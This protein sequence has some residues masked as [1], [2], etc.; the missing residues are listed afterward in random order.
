MAQR[1][2]PEVDPDNEEIVVFFR[3]L[4]VGVGVGVCFGGWVWGARRRRQ[5]PALL[6]QVLAPA[7]EGPGQAAPPGPV[8]AA[9][10]RC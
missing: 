9:L 2:V 8:V 10:R 5:P 3:A 4:Q 7:G 6:A 1:P